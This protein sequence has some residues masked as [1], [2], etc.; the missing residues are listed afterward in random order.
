MSE[1]PSFDQRALHRWVGFAS[2]IFLFFIALTG[3]GLHFMAWWPSR[4][5]VTLIQRVHTGAFLG[6]WG[7]YL[8][9]VISLGIIVLGVTGVVVWSRGR[10]LSELMRARTGFGVRQLELSRAERGETAS[11]FRESDL[12]GDEGI[13]TFVWEAGL[14]GEHQY[15]P[16]LA[17]CRRH[18]KRRLFERLL[19]HGDLE[20]REGFVWLA[21]SVKSVTLADLR[22]HRLAERMLADWWA[23]H[24]DVLH[25]GAHQIEPALD[26]A[27]EDGVCRLLGHP[28]ECP[29]GSPIPRGACCEGRGS[30]IVKSLVEAG[31]T[32]SA[33]FVFAKVEQAY[34]E[35]VRIG[36]LPGV[37]V[38]WRTDGEGVVV[39]HGSQ[40]VQLDSQLARSVLV[41]VV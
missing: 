20:I 7:P 3:I 30:N 36:V 10:Q 6:S 11:E 24:P 23:W 29:H 12:F 39:S 41:A 25:G 27:V 32:G 21:E 15:G 31:S 22:R 8:Y 1:R 9:D 34:N 18:H 13:F 14:K 19:V 2:V 28:K 26:E 16:L 17:W 37:Q 4:E 33:S 40:S 35:L 38:T 5:W